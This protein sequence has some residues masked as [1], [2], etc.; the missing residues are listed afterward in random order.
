MLSLRWVITT[1]RRHYGRP[2]APISKDPF[3]LILW[4]QVGYLVP[5]TQRRRAFLALRTQVGLSPG[6]ILA[7][8]SEQL[9]RITRLGGSIAVTSRAA[10][11]RQSAEVVLGRW[12]GNLRTALHLD[13]RQ[14]RRALVEFPMIG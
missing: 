14:A 13:T 5:D 1:L 6:A 10:R 12:N 8:S 9:E 11:L 4:A 3:H 7:A 2:P